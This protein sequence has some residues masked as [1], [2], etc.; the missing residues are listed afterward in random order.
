MLDLFNQE[1]TQ[2]L[3]APNYSRALIVIVWD[4]EFYPCPNQP[5]SSA[6]KS[7]P[8]EKPPQLIKASITICKYY[9][10]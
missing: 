5:I 6:T 10:I 3:K 7:E 1:I 8:S 4:G 9:S 2:F